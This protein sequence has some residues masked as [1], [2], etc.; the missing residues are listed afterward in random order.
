MISMIKDKLLNNIIIK[1]EEDQL[2]RASDSPLV[3]EQ[4]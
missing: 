4:V 2:I 3:S 1:I